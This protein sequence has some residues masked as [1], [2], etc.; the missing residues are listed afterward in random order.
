MLDEGRSLTQPSGG[1]NRRSPCEL[2]AEAWG[3]FLD[4]IV[5]G[6]EQAR[7]KTPAMSTALV[8]MVKQDIGNLKVLL[9]DARKHRSLGAQGS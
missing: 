2:G 3:S 6:V 8:L 5:G 1:F 7:H 9:A 4:A